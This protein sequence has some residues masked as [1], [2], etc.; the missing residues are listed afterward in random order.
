[1]KLIIQVLVLI[2]VIIHMGL[3]QTPSLR[4]A[5]A[6]AS[7]SSSIKH[8]APSSNTAQLKSNGAVTGTVTINGQP[9]KL[10][11]VFA[12]RTEP[13]SLTGWSE[14]ELF[15][16]NQQLT[17]EALKRITQVPPDDKAPAIRSLRGIY[18]SIGKLWVGNP[19]KIP[20]GFVLIRPTMDIADFQEFSSFNLREGKLEA[21]A[22]G[23]GS[24]E[25]VRWSY[26]LNI[27]ATL[28]RVASPT[29]APLPPPGVVKSMIGIP[30]EAG[31][32]EGSARIEGQNFRLKYAY[33]WREKLFFDEPEEFLHL[34]L[35]EEPLP[36]DEKIYN[37]GFEEVDFTTPYQAIGLA[38][39]LTPSGVARTGVFILKTGS[40]SLSKGLVHNY[41]HNN[42]KVSD[43]KL[44][45]GQVT[46][47]ISYKV[48]SDEFTASFNAP[49]KN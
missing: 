32:A 24:E 45:N 42:L 35:T 31:K 9:I 2:A 8:F 3:A 44:E 5:I 26:S 19:E 21:K 12:R 28:E 7:S 14:I 47:K 33:I 39:K 10:Q 11:Y 22:V 16:T 38:I 49:I 18:I 6:A 41:Q 48:D 43:F 20:Y 40:R 27:S 34:V 4:I 30:P 36:R 37:G 29:G 25:G 15:I 13:S 46:C 17:D 23:S 1:M